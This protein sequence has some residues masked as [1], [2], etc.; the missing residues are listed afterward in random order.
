MLAEGWTGPSQTNQLLKEFGCY[1]HVFLGYCDEELIDFIQQQAITSPGYQQWCRHQREIK[2]RSRVWATAIEQ[3]YWPMGTHGEA[4]QKRKEVTGKVVP[5]NDLR[6]QNAQESI[7]A[8][9]Q[10]LRD[11]DA[12]PEKTTA[13][14]QAVPPPPP[15]PSEKLR[16]S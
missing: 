11:T 1:G 7:K 13:R 16:L 3:Y 10:H 14:A 15:P 8:A 12:L 9:V 2:M 5:F 6:A 4:Q